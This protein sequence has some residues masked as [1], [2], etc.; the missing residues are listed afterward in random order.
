[1]EISFIH[2]GNSQSFV[3]YVIKQMLKGVMLYMVKNNMKKE[4]NE[5]EDLKQ[6]KSDEELNNKCSEIINSLEGFTKNEKLR[7]LTILYDSFMDLLKEEGISFF[8]VRKG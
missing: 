8:E 4:F 1:M 6:L 3:V 2:L 5:D 7:I